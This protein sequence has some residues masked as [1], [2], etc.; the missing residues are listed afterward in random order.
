[1]LIDKPVYV[2]D[3]WISS[4]E[5]DLQRKS[6]RKLW[7][8]EIDYGLLNEQN[9]I[10]RLESRFLPSY[11]LQVGRQRLGLSEWLGIYDSSR[12]DKLSYMVTG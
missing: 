2:K 4:F 10:P 8:W 9:N 12:P 5:K 1:M 6:G 11:H 7:I 3:G